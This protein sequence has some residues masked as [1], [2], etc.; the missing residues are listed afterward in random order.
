MT[1]ENGKR[2][3]GGTGSSSEESSYL[4]QW[5][6][7]GDAIDTGTSPDPQDGVGTAGCQFVDDGE[8]GLCLYVPAGEEMF[9]P[10]P[11]DFTIFSG[12]GIPLDCMVSFEAQCPDHALACLPFVF[13]STAWGSAAGADKRVNIWES[14]NGGDILVETYGYT[15]RRAQSGNFRDGQWHTYAIFHSQFADSYLLVDG[16]P[17]AH[18]SACFIA[19]PDPT[20]PGTGIR[21]GSAGL[22]YSGDVYVRN[23]RYNR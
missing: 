9:I 16:S 22:A 8:G 12:L 17:Y 10:V 18:M 23:L 15:S 2:V 4:H 21:V 11:G 7:N 14:A 3:S 20:S 19:S 6:F 5:R 13:G 1:I